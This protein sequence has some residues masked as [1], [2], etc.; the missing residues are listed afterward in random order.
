MLQL[1]IPNFPKN[2]TLKS[3]ELLCAK[4]CL[5]SDTKSWDPVNAKVSLSEKKEA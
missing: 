5:I 3:S 1:T 4:N 2:N